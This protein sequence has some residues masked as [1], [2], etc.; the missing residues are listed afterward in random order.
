MAGRRRQLADSSDSAT[1]GERIRRVRQDRG[2][3]QT[4]LA[5]QANVNQ[6]YLSSIE[7]GHR[8]PRAATLRAIAVT[9]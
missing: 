3:T 8:M 7:R 4:E 6:G 2:M 5:A 9:L 1:V